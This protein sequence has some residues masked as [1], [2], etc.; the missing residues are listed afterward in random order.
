[1]WHRRQRAQ[2]SRQPRRRSPMPKAAEVHRLRPRPLDRAAG[3]AQLVIRVD[4]ERADAVLRAVNDALA[5]LGSEP[6]DF[7]MLNREQS[8]R[9]LRQILAGPRPGVTLAVWNACL[10]RAAYGTGTIDASRDDLA[11]LAQTTPGE[12]SR[13]M[14]LLCRLGALGK[15]GPARYMLSPELAWRGSQATRAAAV[16]KREPG[17]VVVELHPA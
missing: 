1:M 11:E 6:W 7:V 8:A 4:P 5:S 12:V 15:S 17:A 14:A 3:D 13:A 9:L 2:R 10:I 16:R